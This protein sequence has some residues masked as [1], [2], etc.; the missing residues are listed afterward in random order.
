MNFPDVISEDL[1]PNEGLTAKA[2]WYGISGVSSVLLHLQLNMVI[3]PG[4]VLEGL[5]SDPTYLNSELF[6][7]RNLTVQHSADIFLTWLL[8]EPE[9]PTSL[10]TPRVLKHRDFKI[11]DDSLWACWKWKGEICPASKNIIIL[12]SSFCNFKTYLI[13]TNIEKSWLSCSSLGLMG[14]MTVLPIP[15]LS[16]AS[17]LA[18]SLFNHLTQSLSTPSDSW[19]FLSIFDLRL[20]RT[21]IFISRLFRNSGGMVFSSFRRRKI[22]VRREPLYHTLISSQ[23]VVKVLLLLYIALK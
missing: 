19:E 16:S 23:T 22:S 8:S 4:V 9:Y 15:R 21:L 18:K 12:V 2:A 7:D 6:G 5:E 11:L 3:P 10:S 14:V 17:S 20:P 13:G 1:L